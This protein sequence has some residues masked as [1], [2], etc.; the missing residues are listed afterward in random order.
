MNLDGYNRSTREFLE[1]YGEIPIIAL[2]VVIVPVPFIIPLLLNVLTKREFNKFMKKKGYDRLYHWEL[3]ATLNIDGKKKNVIIQ[4][5]CEIDINFDKKSYSYYYK[6]LINNKRFMDVPLESLKE[7]QLTIIEMLHKT[8][9]KISYDEYYKWTMIGN[10]SCQGFVKSIL[11]NVDLYDKTEELSSHY[12]SNINHTDEEEIIK[13][14]STSLY[15]IDLFC[16]M[17]FYL[18]K[19]LTYLRDDIIKKKLANFTSYYNI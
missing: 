19:F 10:L 4:K 14:H 12:Q 17:C 5:A 18:Y 8:R 15:I 9:D 2:S 3:M 6:S 13:N 1:K 11:E 7:Q 16:F